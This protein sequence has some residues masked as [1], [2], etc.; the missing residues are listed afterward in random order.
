MFPPTRIAALLSSIRTW[1]D[2]KK[3]LGCSGVIDYVLGSKFGFELGC[4]AV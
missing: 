1:A 2:V 4:S 3:P